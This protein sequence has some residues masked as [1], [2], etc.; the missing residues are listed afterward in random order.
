MLA[1][2]IL[3]LLGGATLWWLHRT[4]YLPVGPVLW[5]AVV[6][7]AVFVLNSGMHPVGFATAV[8][9]GALML[10]RARTSAVRTWADRVFAV[11]FWG[12]A[13]LAVTWLVIGLL[14]FV[15]RTVPAVETAF[16]RWGGGGDGPGSWPVVGEVIRRATTTELQTLFGIRS[17]GS[18]TTAMQYALSAMNIALG[19]FLMVLRP[20][21]TVARLLALGMVGTGAVF[22]AEAHT[23]YAISW[24]RPIHDLGFHGVAGMTYLAA[25]VLFP[26]GK[27]KPDWAT[28]PRWRQ[29]LQAAGL[30]FA[31]LL[32]ALWIAST[33]GERPV[34]YVAVFGVLIPVLGL[35]SQIGKFR[36]A[37]DETERRQSRLLATTLVAALAGAV[38]FGII[39]GA[40]SVPGADVGGLE[41]FTFNAFPALFGAIP[42]ILFAILI[43]FRLWDIDRIIN[44][45][46]VYGGLAG[47]IGVA[48]VGIVVLGSEFVTQARNDLWLSILATTVVAVG[49][50]P[51]R[52]RLRSFANRL[53][54]GQRETP[55]EVLAR[56]SGRVTQTYAGDDVLPRIART[57]AAGTTAARADVW[58]VLDGALV[59]TAT[60]PEPAEPAPALP[61]PDGHLP[62]IPGAD[63]SVPVV[64]LGELLGALTLTARP[65]EPVT[66]AEERLLEDLATQAGI[67]LRNVRL[68]EELRE[69]LRVL[70]AQAQELRT[71][72]QRIVAAQDAE[73]RRMERDIHD[74]AQQHLVALA[75][76]LRLARSIAAQDPERAR[77]L[78][79]ELQR[80]VGEALETLRNLARGIYPAVLADQGLIAALRSAAERSP[81]DVRIHADEVDRY[82]RDIETAVYFCV[83]ETLQNA[84]KYSGASEVTVE[85]TQRDGD[86][87]FE[88]RDDGAGFDPATQR[89]G[90]GL[91][92]LADRL[93]ALDG[94]VT[95]D[96]RPGA[97]TTVRGRI[98][99]SVLETVG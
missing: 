54:Y 78:L 82:P 80:E 14:P 64:Y 6:F 70:S 61:M 62:E 52:D 95:V 72:R 19:I 56:F 53:V 5:A 84:A 93:A 74:G 85:L 34:Q 23:A 44:R 42:V 67:V 33:H 63:L 8:L 76:K 83:L 43:R 96:S 49:F 58:V 31:F 11:L 89:R 94:S 16:I 7:A 55:Y 73:R 98:P 30:T 18:A 92:N 50:Q 28:L 69:R 38:T 36:H 90:R 39:A 99:L 59:R 57:V 29:V 79:E 10:G 26:D 40:L 35:A 65:D 71:S 75:V 60:F 15:A 13:A 48:Y 66:P 97:G 4:G 87:T 2:P 27:L 86:L 41:T 21:D 24:L 3:L 32:S 25:I 1:V 20:R 45:G 91:Q 46:F 22:N 88:V 9:L 51:L 47:F 81:L 68:T 12:F 77:P 17:P 37:D